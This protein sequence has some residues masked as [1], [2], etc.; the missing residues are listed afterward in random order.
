MTTISENS[1]QARTIT[2]RHMLPLIGANTLGTASERRR[3]R[4]A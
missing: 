4:H 2:L 1:T 3:W